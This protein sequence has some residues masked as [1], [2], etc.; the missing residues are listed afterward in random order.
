M[1]QR[2]AHG[3]QTPVDC[4][5]D[6]LSGWWKQCL[7]QII[8]RFIS[9]VMF[10]TNSLGSWRICRSIFLA[11]SGTPSS[12]GRL[13]RASS[14]WEILR[15]LTLGSVSSSIDIP[16]S[17]SEPSW[18]GV[19]QA[20]AQARAQAKPKAQARLFAPGPVLWTW[21]PLL[22]FFWWWHL[23]LLQ[24]SREHADKQISNILG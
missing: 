14:L 23:Q 20:L 9:T 12:C 13:V 5:Y 24:F 15:W 4:V 7:Y 16:I 2:R 18:G 8:R 11:S 19:G 21:A 10:V 22:H 1:L 6:M 17:L 3:T